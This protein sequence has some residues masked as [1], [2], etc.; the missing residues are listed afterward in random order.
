MMSPS[1]SARHSATKSGPLVLT[2][3][4][5]LF[6]LLASTQFCMD[7][8]LRGAVLDLSSVV[9]V[10][11]VDPCALLRILAGVAEEVPNTTEWPYR[12]QDCIAMLGRTGLV[13]AL[14]PVASSWAQQSRLS[15]FAEHGVAIGRAAQV[16][17]QGLGVCPES[18]YL[19]GLL[20]EIGDLPAQ[21]GWLGR[22][23]KCAPCEA[24]DLLAMQ[25]HLPVTLR[26]DL[27]SLHAS[28]AG[29]LWPQIIM[30]AHE[31]TGTVHKFGQ[32]AFQSAS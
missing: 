3:Q 25:Y 7:V 21:L 18:A 4:L 23:F 14:T 13:R 17:A 10:L 15:A 11:H 27:L 9:E 19:C 5:P 31:L 8:L 32:Q 26:Y 30:A 20:H 28:E 24:V 2:P 22:D 6:P 29:A 1:E 12:L 16:A